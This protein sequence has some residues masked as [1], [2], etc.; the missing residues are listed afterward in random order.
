MDH[1]KEELDLL[2][3]LV[4]SKYTKNYVS[5]EEKLILRRILKKYLL[6]KI[7]FLSEE[8]KNGIV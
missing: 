6:K 5:Q 3:E 8:L 7:Y 4:Y 1:D 2:I